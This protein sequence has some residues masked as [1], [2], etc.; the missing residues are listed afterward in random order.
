MISALLVIPERCREPGVMP[1]FP[2]DFFPA[3]A[4]RK[5][6]GF[7]TAGFLRK[8][9]WGMEETLTGFNASYND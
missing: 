3:T 6:A 5:L 8:I 7:C 2:A 4:V 9:P 1:C